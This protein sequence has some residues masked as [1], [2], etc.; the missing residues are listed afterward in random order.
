[1]KNPTSGGTAREM[2]VILV[3]TGALGYAFNAL[4]PLGVRGYATAAATYSNETVAASAE[5]APATTVDPRYGNDTV[6]VEVLQGAKPA[7]RAAVPSP[8]SPMGWDEIKPLL[9]AGK[10]ALVDARIAADYQAGHIPGAESL[11]FA[12][13]EEN[14]AAFEARHPKSQMIVVYCASTTCRVSSAEAAIIAQRYGYGDVHEMPG[15]FAEYRL[16]EPAGSESGKGG[17]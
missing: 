17:K 2:L 4:S 14:I 11:P 7:A 1:M 5:P 13:M 6:Q 16:A 8:G 15:G 12:D 10:V 3:T 9:A